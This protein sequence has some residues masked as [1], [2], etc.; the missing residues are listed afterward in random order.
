VVAA[1]ARIEGL[2]SAMAAMG[3]AFPKDP[4]QQ[5]RLVNAAMRSAAVQTILV[6]AKLRAAAMDGSG[7]L[8]ESIGIR[9]KSRKKIMTARRVGGIEVTPIRY[10]AKAMAMYI[11]HYYTQRGK[12][13]DQSV[14]IDGI[15][16]GHLVEFGSKNNAA[17]PFLWPAARSKKTAYTNLFAKSLKKKTE[18]AVKRR[19]KRAGKR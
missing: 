12:N 6:S 15:R 2:E 10:N 3:A 9:A 18:L 16:H 7:A 1:T 19:A 14:A 13:P 4:S 11:N 8:A 17:R 5:S